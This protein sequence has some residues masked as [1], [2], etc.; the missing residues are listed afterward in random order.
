MMRFRGCLFERLGQHGS[1]V[2][3]V[4]DVPWREADILEVF[5]EQPA[6]D[7]SAQQLWAAAEYREGANR[8]NNGLNALW[9]ATLDCDC[10]DI[11]T[12][13]AV[14]EYVRAQGLA[15]MAY[16]S[17]SHMDATKVHKDTGRVGPFDAFR[18]V[19]PYSRPLSPAEHKS[20]VPA[21][22]GFELP[23]D[24]KHYTKEVIGRYVDRGKIESAAKPRGWDPKSWVPS[25]GFF[26]PSSKSSIDVFQGESL[27]VDAVLARP[28]TA[29]VTSLRA[30]PFQAPS[31]LAMGALGVTLRALEAKGIYAS[32]PNS[33]GWYRSICPSCASAAQGQRSPSF[34]ARANGDSVDLWCH[35]QCK[36]PQLLQALGVDQGGAFRPSSDLRVRLEEQLV[37]QAPPEDDIDVELATERLVEDIREAVAARKPTIVKY[38]A[39]TGKTVASAKIITEHVRAGFRIAYSTICLLYTSPSPRD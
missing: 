1:R 38:P 3:T 22:I 13:D 31:R 30:R 14:I 35:A 24:P 20:V 7:K 33:E 2:E 23:H 39:G 6:I 32:G 11:G 15:F 5:G 10:A 28:L 18:L 17:W 25:Q 16:T 12:L 37:S 8:G 4:F 21:L 29:R 36:H 34:T 19:I 27:N 26:V 9:A